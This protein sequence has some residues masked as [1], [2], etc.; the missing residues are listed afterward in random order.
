MYVFRLFVLWRVFGLIRFFWVTGFG[1][2]D[3]VDGVN[4]C[5]DACRIQYTVY[6][7]EH[8]HVR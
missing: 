6:I 2:V 7:C 5:V 8:P 4:K 3:L 1:V